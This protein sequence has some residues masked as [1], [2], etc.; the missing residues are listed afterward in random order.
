M[1]PDKDSENP[2]KGTLKRTITNYLNMYL[3]F[4]VSRVYTLFKV[5]ILTFLP[6]VTS[7]GLSFQLS[8]AR[9][10]SRV[11]YTPFPFHL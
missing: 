8:P 1:I 7:L 3:Y 5:T 2:G 6:E 10:A 11:S 4:S 9:Q